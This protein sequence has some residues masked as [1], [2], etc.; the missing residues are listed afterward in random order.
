[1]LRH[2]ALQQCARLAIGIS[3]VDLRVREGLANFQNTSDLTLG[4]GKTKL[5]PNKQL[6]QV[7]K[8]KGI[9]QSY[10]T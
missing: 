6:T 5:N 9:L 3:E 10:S 4:M 2:R 1:M 7:D 8:L